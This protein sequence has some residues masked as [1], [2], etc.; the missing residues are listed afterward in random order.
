MQ[1]SFMKFKLSILFLLFVT[2]SFAQTPQ[3]INYQAIA[4]DAGGNIVTNS[5]GIK[6]RILQGSTSGTL[7][8]EE[9]HTST[10]SS[11][12]IF[13]VGIGAGTVVSGNFSAINWQNSPYYLEVNIDPSGGTSY[14]T[15]GTTQLVSVPYALYAEKAGNATSYSAGNGISISS[16]SIT[17]AAPDQTIT[18]APGTNVSVNGSYPNFTVNSTPS[19]AIT[20]NSLSISGGN[21]VL[22][23]SSGT[24]VATP[25]TSITTTGNATVTT[26]GT[27]T[28]NIAV[29]PQTLSLS[30]GVLSISG[31]NAVTLPTAPITTITGGGLATVTPTTGSN[32]NVTVPAQTLSLGGNILGISGGNSVTLPAPPA[33]TITG[34]G[35]AVVTPTVGNNININVPTPSF[36]GTNGITVSGSYPAFSM[37][38]SSTGTNTA[39]NT[40]G[41][42]A[43]NGS[44]NFIG[45]TDAQP[46]NFRTS[47]STRLFISPTGA[48]GIGNTIPSAPLEVTGKTITDSIQ[49]S[50]SVTPSTGA[51]LVSRDN[52]GNAKWS[53]GISFRGEFAPATPITISTAVQ[54]NI[55][56]TAGGYSSGTIF[57]NA[58][59]GGISFLTTGMRFT[60]PETGVYF[61]EASLMVAINSSA[62]GNNY[63]ALEIY[64][65]TT[66]TILSRTM[67]SNP[68][69]ASA[70]NTVLKT[71]TAYALTK[72]DVIILR[73]MGST[74][75]AGTISNAYPQTNKMDYF[76]GYLLR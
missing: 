56:N 37:G 17:N 3:V 18:L 55:G 1:I 60:V 26:T 51:V 54:S 49:I 46:L 62:T 59:T 42:S 31:G 41:N 6:F 20:G 50:G 11:A 25:N 35:I 57:N 66:A 72:N 74:A 2:L 40:N 4:R 13:N 34:S 28:F 73:V 14:S 65:S 43:T 30:A 61:L 58:P 71:G 63:V 16:G 38:I 22:I 15:I 45:T 12:G 47:N 7:V 44:V 69:N 70:M 76:T 29:A 24:F 53:A 23:P 19:L 8:Y 9:T 75:T 27:N 52:I 64:N 36:T 32:F 39:W 5:I 21:G 67:Q 33:Q 68:D 48:V 10:P